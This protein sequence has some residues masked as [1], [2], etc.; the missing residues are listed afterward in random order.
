M[1][2]ATIRAAG[3][4]PR[5]PAGRS[6]PD[7]GA[8]RRADR[9]EE[10][11]ELQDEAEQL[12]EQIRALGDQRQRQQE[13]LATTPMVFHYGSGDLVPGYR[14]P[15]TLGRRCSAPADNFVDGAT[16]LLILV[17]TLRPGCSRWC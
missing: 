17:I 10:R 1:S 3:R 12:R 14:P 7:R 6:R 11:A 16:M 4:R 15:Q 13:S 9:D 5:R 8:A 2:A